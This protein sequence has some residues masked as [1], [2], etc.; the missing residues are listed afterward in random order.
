MIGSLRGALRRITPELLLLDVG[1]VGYAVRA[2]LSTYYE[3]AQ[4]AAGSEVELLVHTQVRDDAIELFGFLTELELQLFQQLISVNGI[5]P[6]L[7]QGVLSG[8]APPELLAAVA[9]GD[10][11]RLVRIPGVGKKTAERMV[12][13]LRDKAA[14]LA[15]AAGTTVA[16]VPSED[17]DLVEA[18]VNFGYRQVAAERAVAHVRKH[19]P[20]AEF[21]E[22]LRLSLRDISK[23]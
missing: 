17:H 18:L 2:P 15:A 16:A 5:G 6:R 13:E 23:L 21:G 8:M 3:L 9:G 10:V 1:G 12:L 22:L 14:K 4:M 19:H 7:A 11:A 20:D